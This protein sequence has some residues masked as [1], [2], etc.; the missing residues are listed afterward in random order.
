MNEISILAQTTAEQEPRFLRR[1]FTGTATRPQIIF[2]LVVGIILPI[3]CLIFDPIVFRGSFGFG[4]GLLKSF[5]LFAYAVI[6]LEVLTLGLWLMWGEWAGAWR[7]AIGGVLL[8]GAFFSFLIAI[9]LLPFSLMGLA[10]IQQVSATQYRSALEPGSTP[11]PFLS[12]STRY[13]C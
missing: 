3:L 11:V 5:Q 1:Q 8:A 6:G 4:G 10:W 12:A 9:I 2:D 7:S 13:R